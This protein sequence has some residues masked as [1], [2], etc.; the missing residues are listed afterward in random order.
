M[1]SSTIYILVLLIV[2][3][4]SQLILCGTPGKI[5]GEI[6]DS[7]T[8]Q[9]LLGAIVMLEKTSMGAA[10]DIDGKYFISNVPT[11]HY[12]LKVSYIGYKTV[13]IKIDLKDGEHLQQNFKLQPVGVSGE[14]VVVTAQASGQNAA[15]NQQLSSQNIV[16]VVSA[17]RIQELP[18][19]NAA[20]SVGRLS[21]VYLLRSGGE[22]Y[23]VAI[24]GL[25]PKYNEIMIDGVPMPATDYDNRSVDMS[26]I[27]SNML[28]GIEVFKTVS[29]DMDASVLGG[30]VNFQIREA[31][32]LNSGAPEVNLSLQGRYENL[33]ST[34]NDYKFSGAI[35]DRFL[36]DRLGILAEGVVEKINLTSDQL[37]ANYGTPIPVNTTTGI[38]PLNNITPTY[39]PK[40]R[41]R[42]GATFTLDYKLPEGKIDLMNFFSSSDTKTDT[43]DQ[44][45]DINNSQILYDAGYTPIT[46][47]TITDLLALKQKIF[48]FDADVRI[49]HS[50]TENINRGGWSVDF[51]QKPVA[52][53][54]SKIENLPPVDIAQI[55]AAKID[56]TKMFFNTIST[57]NS[58]LKH[59]DISG[60]VDLKK[61]F[62]FSDLVSATIKFGGMF[63]YTNSY[64]DYNTGTGSLWYSTDKDSRQAI[65]DAFPWLA[66]SY[67][68]NANSQFPVTAFLDPGFSY[69]KFLN[70]NYSMGSGTNIG[71]LSQVVG[72][73]VN[74]SLGKPR[75][76]GGSSNPYAVDIYGSDASDYTGNEH[77]GA[78]YIMTTVN[79]GPI[80][81]I[82][83]GVR[84]QELQTTYEASKYFNA[85]SLNY[86]HTD[87]TINEYH[88]YWL[89]DVSVRYKPLTW[90]DIRTA[91]T[92][93]IN[94]PSFNQITPAIDVNPTA[95]TVLWHNYSLQPA[96]S[97]NYDL[98]LSAYDN[99]IGLLTI[100]GYL[101]QIDHLIFLSQGVYITDPTQYPG[102]P[103]STKGYTLT[104]SVNNP[105]RVNIWGI[106]FDW[107]THFWYLPGPLSGLVMNINYTHTFSKATYPYVITGNTGYPLYKPV[108]TDT[109]YSDRLINQP[110]DIVNLSLGFDYGKFSAL[111]S[112]IYQAN[113][114]FNTNFFQQNRSFKDNYLRLDFSAKQSLPW[115]RLEAF[116]DI[117]NINGAND[118]YLIQYGRYPYSEEDYGMTMDIG[119]RWNLE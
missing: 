71:L 36:N 79:I 84:F 100:G 3:F 78:G 34:Y 58:Y 37:N 101:K 114:F 89:P 12:S 8:N 31:K 119:L 65:L 81:T 106:E 30:V 55:G 67:N 63:K 90:L 7:V 111:F 25:Q 43:R 35:G 112:M 20:E 70:G 72:V 24:R 94:Y 80:V 14:E 18:D 87:T 82:I 91:Y 77:Q 23:A 48:D 9:P 4:A 6:I 96:K 29:P 69:G 118:L 109:T 16:N 59:R 76:S 53:L 44:E 83:P 113:V 10:A 86:T 85:G 60:S 45:Y 95:H 105:F 11:G 17:A 57:N 22:G 66:Q 56:M 98:T 32:K 33:Q 117:N 62:N 26:M 103:S 107:Q 27:S 88:G 19:A 50:F 64:Y 21:G 116:F 73:V 108:Y 115:F 41:R 97:Q 46:L 93:T 5:T 74:N 92:N 52:G 102:L 2:S 15:I 49:S 104:T 110:N 13:T 38:P 51:L 39:S 42:Y 40:E 68:L 47:N 1:K 61:S 75:Q 99:T 28:S 54:D